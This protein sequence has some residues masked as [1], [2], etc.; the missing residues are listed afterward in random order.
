MVTQEDAVADEGAAL[1]R[2]KIL[3]WLHNWLAN[4]Q[5]SRGPAGGPYAPKLVA[6][7]TIKLTIEAIERGDHDEEQKLT[8]CKTEL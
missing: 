3:S 7:T 4:V 6:C 2:C 8:N 1:E 5:N